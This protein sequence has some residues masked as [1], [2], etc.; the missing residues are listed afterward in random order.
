MK[1]A[2]IVAPQI[3]AA[4]LA[5]WIG[6]FSE[7]WG[8]KPLLLV[9][10]GVEIARAVMFG[11]INSSTLL[12]TVQLLDGI[13][14]AIRTVLTTVIDARSN[15]RHRSLQSGARRGRSGRCRCVDR[16]DAIWVHCPGDG[17]LGGIPEHGHTNRSGRLRG[18]ASSQRKQAGE[19]CRLSAHP[20]SA[21]RSPEEPSETGP[22]LLSGPLF[23]ASVSRRVDSQLTPI[24]GSRSA[25]R[26]RARCAAVLPR[27]RLLKRVAAVDM[28][29]ENGWA[30]AGA[31]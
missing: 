25:A 4:L 10:F 6:Y 5:P 29:Y 11:F 26:T 24:W 23:A 2:L 12:I 28:F 9:S 8:R 17:S 20:S 30:P 16:H 7:L 14:G 1:S 21:E 15:N 31:R 13:S 27:A 3:V 22:G 19:L 18:V